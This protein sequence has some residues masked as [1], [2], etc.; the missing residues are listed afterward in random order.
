MEEIYVCARKFTC[1]RKVRCTAKTGVRM[2]LSEHRYRH[3]EVKCRIFGSKQQLIVEG[4]F[5]YLMRE[6]A[7]STEGFVIELMEEYK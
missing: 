7:F 3:G 1:P 4:G 2:S 5:E 6:K